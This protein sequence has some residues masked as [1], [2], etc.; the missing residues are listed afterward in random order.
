MINKPMHL[1][2]LSLIIGI[3]PMLVVIAASIIASLAG[4][5]PNERICIVLGLDIGP[6]IATMGVIGWFI[7]YTIPLALGGTLLSFIWAVKNE[8]S[9]KSK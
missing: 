6:L 5:N 1:F 8:F 4:C 9:K 7:F 2:L 3:F